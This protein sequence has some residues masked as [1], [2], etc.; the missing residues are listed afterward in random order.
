MSIEINEEEKLER[1][2]GRDPQVTIFLR[3]IAPPAALGL[4]GFAGSTFITASY[5]AGWW[6]DES[7][8]TIFFP[9]VMIWGG[10]GQFI[11]GFFGYHARDTLVTVVHV[12]WG[13]FWLGFG[14]L[15]LLIV[16]RPALPPVPVHRTD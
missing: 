9:F 5:I 4:A 3:P 12:L 7:S 15:S 2:L 13:S 1:V 11:A 6:G 8:P 16:G 14:L 10:L